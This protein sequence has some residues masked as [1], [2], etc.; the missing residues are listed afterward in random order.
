[1]LSPRSVLRYFL[2]LSAYTRSQLTQ[3]ER[4]WFFSLHTSFH[5]A[6]WLWWGGGW[7][8][9][10]R[11]LFWSLISAQRCVSDTTEVEAAVGRTHICHHQRWKCGVW[12]AGGVLGL[13]I[14]LFVCGIRAH[15]RS[16]HQHEALFGELMIPIHSCGLKC[17]WMALDG[18]RRSTLTD[19]PAGM[20]RDDSTEPRACWD[21]GQGDERPAGQTDM[22]TGRKITATLAHLSLSSQRILFVLW[23]LPIPIPRLPWL[24]TSH[25]TLYSSRGHGCSL[26]FWSV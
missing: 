4:L 2:S 19:S 12:V 1:M 7:E 20:L 15:I 11:F 26:S 24:L 21:R 14:T 5:G 23:N 10:Q 16:G 9:L 8:L 22:T 6:P 13:G 3:S 18:H 17:P 25:L